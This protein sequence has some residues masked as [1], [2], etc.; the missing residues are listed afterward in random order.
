MVLLTALLLAASMSGCEYTDAGGPV[1]GPARSSQP[2]TPLPTKDEATL[3]LDATNLVAVKKLLGTATGAVL[4]EDSGTASGSSSGIRKSAIVETAG[5]Y[6][7]SASCIGAS[8][9][10]LVIGQVSEDRPRTAGADD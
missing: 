2:R 4:L 6:T 1:A 7:V 9:A 5:S 10:L 8:N 3:A